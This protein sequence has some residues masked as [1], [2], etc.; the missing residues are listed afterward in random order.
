MAAERGKNIVDD[1]ISPGFRARLRPELAGAA[2]KSQD[3]KAALTDD[4]LFRLS[5]ESRTSW[6]NCEVYGYIHRRRHSKYRKNICSSAIDS[7]HARTATAVNW[8]QLAQRG[9][10]QYRSL[11]KWKLLTKSDASAV[12]TTRASEYLRWL[13]SISQPLC[14]DFENGRCHRPN[15]RFYHRPEAEAL[16]QGNA[17]AQQAALGSMGGQVG[18]SPYGANAG[19][20]MGMGMAGMQA[21]YGA[22]QAS[23]A[24]GSGGGAGGYGMQSGGE[25]YSSDAMAQY[26]A[27]AASQWVQS[28]SQM[29]PNPSVPLPVPQPPVGPMAPIPPVSA[30]AYSMY[31]TPLFLVPPQVPAGQPPQQTGWGV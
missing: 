4:D 7:G 29:A 26:Y 23:A 10:C 2:C 1:L 16:Q 18:V 9:K 15:C 27:N 14:R 11:T 5:S 22:A 30:P 12:G 3:G 28:Y 31:G 21:P 8:Q 17:A 25:A 13:G 24:P 19:M 6:A 20:G